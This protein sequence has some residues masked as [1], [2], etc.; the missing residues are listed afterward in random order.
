MKDRNLFS[1]LAAYSQN[2][3]KQSLE[4]FV[5]EL[6]AHFFNV[7]GVFR[8]K[9]LGTIFD[10]QRLARPFQRAKATTQETMSHDCRVDLVL[11]SRAKVHLV[12]VKISAGE[13]LSGRWGQVGKPQVQRYLDLKCGHVTYLTTRDVLPPEVDGRGRKYRM[14]KHALFEELHTELSNQRL[15]AL[16]QMF[17]E[18][19]EEHDMAAPKPFTRSELKAAEQA[20]A[21][22]EKCRSTLEIV[23]NE[24]N[25][26]FR[27]NFRT[28]CSL[29]RPARKSWGVQSY[30]PKFSRGPVKWVGFS[31][32]PADG[33]LF[34][35]VWMVGTRHPIVAKI[36]RHIDWDELAEDSGCCWEI[37]L[38]GDNGDITRMIKHA[39]KASRELG[40]AIRKFT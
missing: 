12:E 29:T 20:L 15:D 34:F 13:T 27:A 4:N 35:S 32:Q 7:S 36:R 16:A 11:R 1:R 21:I 31:L 10:D 17:R 19:M 8:R 28:R 37:Q 2:P 30:L 40:R 5:T 25:A 39:H 26:G 24:V 9:F 6:L 33:K 18:F 3:Q 14:V 22:V 38:R 23:A